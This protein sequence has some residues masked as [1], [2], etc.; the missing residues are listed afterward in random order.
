MNKRKVILALAALLLLISL[1]GELLTALFFEDYTGRVH[2]AVPVFFLA[3][4]A[5]PVAIMAQPKD[6]K[7]FIKQF[8][9]FKSLKFVFLLCAML[10]MCFIF[11]AQ[12]VGVLLSFLIYSLVLIVVENLYVLKLKN[13]F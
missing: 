5:I 9:I 6:A 10:A 4:Y 8:M 1:A 3:L 11:K 2:L 7:Q 13:K 12:A